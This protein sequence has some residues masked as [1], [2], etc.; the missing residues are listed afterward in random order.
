MARTPSSP[1]PSAAFSCLYVGA[2]E[3]QSN[4]TS[5][6]YL[7]SPFG[8]SLPLPTVSSLITVECLQGLERPVPQTI[9]GRNFAH[10]CRF[11]PSFSMPS[12]P[13]SSES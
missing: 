12:N 6:M 10:A 2:G 11:L 4:C 9:P 1:G 3:P 5:E 8:Q 7:W 13:C